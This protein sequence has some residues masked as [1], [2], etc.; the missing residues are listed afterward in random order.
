MVQQRRTRLS[1]LRVLPLITCQGTPQ[2]GIEARYNFARNN[3]DISDL[4]SE[5]LARGNF[6][7]LD[8]APVRNGLVEG[9]RAWLDST[10][11]TH[12]ARG[13]GDLESFARIARQLRVTPVKRI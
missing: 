1:T 12:P 10:N 3:I 6:G 2:R 8:I 13:V 4:L 7:T 9:G 11:C 5:G